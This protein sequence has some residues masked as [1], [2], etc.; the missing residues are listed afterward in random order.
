[1]MSAITNNPKA[2]KGIEERKTSDRLTSGGANAF[3]V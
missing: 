1:M 2:K 3:M